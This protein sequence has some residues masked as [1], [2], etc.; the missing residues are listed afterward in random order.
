MA[1]RSNTHPTR[2]ADGFAARPEEAVKALG[3]ASQQSNL[4][5]A[6]VVDVVERLGIDFSTV[7]FTIEDLRLGLEVESKSGQQSTTDT[8]DGD[9]VEL[10]TIAV[11]NLHERL[12]YYTQLTR[13]HA[14][15]DLTRLL[16]AHSNVGTD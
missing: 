12:D 10:G 1:T 16:H 13:A 7:P 2:R 3:A 4:T 5:G 11:A 8:L 15:G 14:P 6:D 9:L